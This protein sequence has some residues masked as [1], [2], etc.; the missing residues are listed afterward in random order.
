MNKLVLAALA[1]SAA[2]SAPALATTNDIGTVNVSGTVAG[3]CLFTTNSQTITIAELAKSGSDTNAGKLDPT[4]LVNQTKTLVGWCN[5]SASTMT[6]TAKPLLGS[7]GAPNSYFD[8]RIDLTATAVANGQ[9]ATDSS[10]GETVNS[11][12]A[13]SAVT[14][15][16]FSGNVVV[17]L[18]GAATPNNGIL[19]AGSYTGS[20]DVTLAPAV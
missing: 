12:V 2:I 18:I 8:D 5:K 9:T 20:V 13:G 15:G 16:T 4:S 19:T 1:A 14:V 10:S 17:T 3:R 7:T 6:V 11:Y